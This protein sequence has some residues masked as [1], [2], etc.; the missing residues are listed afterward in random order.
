MWC[1]LLIVSLKY[2]YY[3]PTKLGTWVGIGSL[4]LFVSNQE[5]GDKP[6]PTRGWGGGLNQFFLIIFVFFGILASEHP[7]ILSYFWKVLASPPSK[8]GFNGASIDVRLEV[9]NR[10]GTK[11]VRC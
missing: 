2:T 11:M 5:A 6:P 7:P 1:A 4:F 10:P 9:L 3:A 8:A